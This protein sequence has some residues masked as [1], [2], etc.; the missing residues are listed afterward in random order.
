MARSDVSVT[1][2]ISDAEAAALASTFGVE[3]AHGE[4]LV[5]A[6]TPL[7]RGL[8]AAAFREY[9]LTITGERIPTGVRDIRELRLRLMAEHL[10]GS[11][12][13]DRQVAQ[14]FGLTSSQARTLVAGTRARYPQE[15]AGLVVTAAKN[16]LRQATK[17]DDDTVRITASDSLVAFLRDVLQD[18][19]A[20]PPLRRPDV[21]LRYDLNR[22]TVE[23][24]CAR[25]GLDISAVKA[26]P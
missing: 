21:S 11:L 24:L 18:S 10:P 6:V 22:Q 3:P 15:F 7:V 5:E 1:V 25:L 16:A 9:L 2:P 8:A 23:E 20:P 14:L 17:V 12:P 4:S 13:S 19:V 26:L